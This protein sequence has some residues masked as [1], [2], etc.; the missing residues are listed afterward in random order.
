VFASA[1]HLER[2]EI[3]RAE[4]LVRAS[5]QGVMRMAVYLRFSSERQSAPSLEDQLRLCRAQLL[6]GR[7]RLP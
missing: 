6:D 4:A 7:R 1:R 5:R 2:L 3:R